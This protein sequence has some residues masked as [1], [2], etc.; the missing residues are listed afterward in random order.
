MT[1][2]LKP[3]FA[4]SGAAL[5]TVEAGGDVDEAVQEA[6]LKLGIGKP[7]VQSDADDRGPEGDDYGF[8]TR[9]TDDGLF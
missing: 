1:E 8:D 3:G 9:D 2:E 6:I 7:R 4:I 5:R